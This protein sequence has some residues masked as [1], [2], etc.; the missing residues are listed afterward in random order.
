[1]ANPQ[2]TDAHIRITHKLWEQIM[3]SKFTE[4]QI[5]PVLLIF[6]LSWG[7]GKKTAII[8][9]Q[10][11]FEVVGVGK[12]HIKGILSWLQEAK[13]ITRNGNEYSINENHDQ[14]R[15]SRALEYTHIRVTDLVSLNLK[16]LP[17][18]ELESYRKGNFE[19]TE[20]VNSPDT[21]LTTAKEK[22]KENIKEDDDVLQ[23]VRY[24]YQKTFG[25]QP[26]DI[27]VEELVKAQAIY[28]QDWIEEAF[29]AA[30][31]YGAQ[32]WRYVKVVLESWARDGY[33]RGNWHNRGKEGDAFMGSDIQY[34]QPQEQEQKAIPWRKG[35]QMD[36]VCIRCGQQARVYVLKDGSHHVVCYPCQRVLHNAGFY[37][38]TRPMRLITCADCGKEARVNI[39]DH[40][41]QHTLCYPCRWKEARKQG[42]VPTTL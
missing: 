25:K 31:E 15:V 38:S 2:P 22:I 16:Q 32:N 3:T 26:P 6:R 29:C 12:C 21:N 4:R 30:A 40:E 42:K 27:L 10:A 9:R 8:P 24:L 39:L 19:V 36:I 28:P 33:N 7:C 41:P 14:W 18:R 5:R 37:D 1:M 11:D 35:L 17:N 23:D 20:K 13:V 34:S